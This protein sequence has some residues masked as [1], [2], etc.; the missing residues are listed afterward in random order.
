MRRILSLTGAA[1]VLLATSVAAQYQTT[2][3][4]QTAPELTVNPV[5]QALDSGQA[6]I[7]DDHGVQ[8]RR[9]DA[10]RRRLRVP[11]D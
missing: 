9:R 8:P 10:V 7:G 11:L 1:L 4:Q 6:V 3:S 2:P 5:K